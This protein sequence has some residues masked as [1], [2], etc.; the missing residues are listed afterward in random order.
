MAH[1]DL[2]EDHVMSNYE[3]Y[4]DVAKE[5][6][7]LCREAKCEV[8]AI[9]WSEIER[10]RDEMTHYRYVTDICRS[11]GLPVDIVKEYVESLTFKEL[12]AI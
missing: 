9:F 4:I 10:Q 1:I 5:M 12:Y 11:T 7:T 8:D 2:L 3:Y 6:E